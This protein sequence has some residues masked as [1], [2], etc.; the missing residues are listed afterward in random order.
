MLRY[1]YMYHN[2]YICTHTRT[3]AHAHTHIHTHTYTHTYAIISDVP[4]YM[5][6]RNVI[7]S[8]CRSKMNVLYNVLRYFFF[9]F[10]ERGYGPY[11]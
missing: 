10:Q 9:F 8:I 4:M 1:T 3:H 2:T 7:T 5:A 11:G 6:L